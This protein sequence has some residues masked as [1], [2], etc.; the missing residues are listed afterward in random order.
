MLRIVNGSIEKV[1]AEM[2]QKAHLLGIEIKAIK[3]K[4]KGALKE[5]KERPALVDSVILENYQKKI[6]KLEEKKL[7][8]GSSIIPVKVD[9]VI[10]NFKLYEIFMNKVKDFNPVIEV[11]TGILIHYRTG[12]VKSKGRLELYD[13]SHHFE[14]FNS[15]PI[16]EI[17]DEVESY[18]T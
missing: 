10:I 7:F 18:G 3:I 8:Y 15:I 2:K 17:V 9:S 5:K 14:D 11:S 13:L 6:D 1:K 12:V 16:A 4:Y